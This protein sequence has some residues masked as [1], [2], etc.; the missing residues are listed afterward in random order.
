MLQALSAQ[1]LYEN[2]KQAELIADF[3]YKKFGSDDDWI[4]Y[5][6]EV[7]EVQLDEYGDDMIRKRIVKKR[8]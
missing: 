8:K 1:Y 2:E 7:E 5:E 6:E 3:T 4:D